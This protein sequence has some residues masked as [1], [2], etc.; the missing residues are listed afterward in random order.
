MDF[1]AADL[2]GP[3]ELAQDL[4][5]HDA[6]ALRPL[7][8]RQDHHELVAALAGD[9]VHLAH[10]GAQAPRH[11][12]QDV[13]AGVVAQR[14]VEELEAVEVEEEHRHVALLA[15]RLHDRLVEAVL[16]EAPVGQPRERVVVRH[17]VDGALGVQ[18]LGHV[19]DEGGEA[20]DAPARVDERRVV[21]LA[22]DRVPA[23]GHVLKAHLGA[24]AGLH[25]LQPHRLH[26]V[27]GPGRHDELR[28]ALADRIAPG[29]AED[30]LGRG[31]PRGH[32][33]VA[34]PLDH[35]ERRA[36]DVHAHLLRGDELALL[37]LQPPD[38]LLGQRVV[39]L[40]QALALDLELARERGPVLA[41][42]ER[43]DERAVQLLVHVG[44]DPGEQQDRPR[45]E[46]LRPVA[47]EA[48]GE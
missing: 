11:V 30:R 21:P 9:G 12:L 34:V 3:R 39:G 22:L 41:R 36:L 38:H 14:V 6:R 16:H 42:G 32:A 33:V 24:V 2:H 45:E 26:R 19:L 5:G 47:G 8:V 17:V 25:E 23:A 29:E 40:L 20:H 46:H 1:L 15:A 44:Q 10:A 13:V 7:E 27:G 37:R 35:G 48:E 28:R 43:I 31:V 4:V 18:A